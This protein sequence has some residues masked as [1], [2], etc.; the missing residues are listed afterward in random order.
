MSP[1][2]SV[3]VVLWT[4][5]YNKLHIT[6]MTVYMYM[7][8]HVCILHSAMYSGVSFTCLCTLQ[9]LSSVYSIMRYCLQGRQYTVHVCVQ[10]YTIIK[11]TTVY[12]AF[13]TYTQRY[14]KDQVVYIQ[15]HLGKD[16]R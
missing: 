10:L 3:S 14:E 4:Y 12:L 1:V 8:I 9:L 15:L 13:D 6:Y 16:L 11:S 7:Y 2:Q 5:T